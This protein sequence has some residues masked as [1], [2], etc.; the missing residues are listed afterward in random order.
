MTVA[1]R[2]P[3]PDRRT[4]EQLAHDKEAVRKQVTSLTT[5]NADDDARVAQEVFVE[6]I[7]RR[8]LAAPADHATPF[9]HFVP[10]SGTRAVL[11]VANELVVDAGPDEL[12]GLLPGYAPADRADRS[13]R[14]RT[15]VL[16]S[17][18][19]KNVTEL[20]ADAKRLRDEKKIMANV[21]SIVPLGYVIK[22]N[23][24][25]GST[26]APAPFA[27]QGA[28]APVRVAVIDTGITAEARSD[29]WDTGVV[30]EGTDPVNVLAPLDRI[31][32]F[33]GHG[34]FA[35]G[36]VRQIAPDCEVVVYRFTSTD[37]L[38]TDEAAADMMIKAAE[39]ANGGRL[40]INASFGAPAVDG[41]PPLAMQEA[42]A[43]IAAEHPQVLIVASAGN[44]GKDLPL[45]P[46]AFPGV[47]AVGA[48]NSDLTPA[49]FSNHGSWVHCSTVGVGI[50]STF[51][52]GKLPPE[53]HIGDDV[54]FGQ[55]PW[56]TWSGT[57]F[58]APQ[59]SAAVAALCGE[60]ATL[61]P[62]AAFD[63]LVTGRP[64]VP[65]LGTAVHLLPGTP[66]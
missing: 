29:G 54:T 33:A 37:G 40:I 42:V 43:H 61:T 46:A 14:R 47:K 19:R 65:E 6:R 62:K 28:G 45:Y 12:D 4:A 49:N 58:T 25:P 13:P 39:D 26:V 11:A 8:Q 41:V 32:W 5:P 34:T 53:D 7:Q 20:R 21:N 57:S 15:R 63:Q 38:G 48:L 17:E 44:D 18:G 36:I 66:L 51:V 31:D 3:L 56:A 22:G 30:R 35:A 27:A 9:L 60:N 1:S 50:V 10:R 52:E 64:G 55:D 16:R 24:Y 59:I 23:S 2:W